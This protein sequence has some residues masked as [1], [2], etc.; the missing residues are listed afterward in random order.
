MGRWHLVSAVAGR[1]LM[2]A[3]RS[4]DNIMRAVDKW[5]M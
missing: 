4:I 5:S 1:E 3:I 2:G